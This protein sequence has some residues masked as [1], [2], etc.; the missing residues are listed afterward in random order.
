MLPHYLFYNCSSLTE[1]KFV[2]GED[3]AVNYFPEYVTFVGHYLL[4]GTGVTSFEIKYVPDFLGAAVFSGC[5]DLTTVV[6]NGNIEL[7]DGTHGT[8]FSY[9]RSGLNGNSYGN[10]YFF[11]NC[12]SLTDVGYYSEGKVTY[13]AFSDNVSEI[14]TGMFKNCSS[15]VNFK[16]SNYITA[17]GDEAFSG[18]KK[19]TA[20]DGVFMLP[21][22]VTELRPYILEDCDSIT[23]VVLHSKVRDFVEQMGNSYSPNW[24]YKAIGVRAFRGMD[25]LTDIVVPSSFGY[26]IKDGLLISDD[27]ILWAFPALTQGIVEIPEEIT[28]IAALAFDGNEGLTEVVYNNVKYV[29]SYAFR[30]CVNYCPSETDLE[31]L[32]Y[33][34][35][36]SP[37]YEGTKPKED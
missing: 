35:K 7:V 22:L 9:G 29:G 26:I 17:I 1:I 16:L 23:T 6:L 34:N 4:A 2:N 18:C 8:S 15:L 24:S 33:E 14:P 3:T 13:G 31:N 19:W 12:T 36:Y 25:N 11:E 21:S 32:T 20:E 37:S 30:N 27:V 28:V 5:S 10:S